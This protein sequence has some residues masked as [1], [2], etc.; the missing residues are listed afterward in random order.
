MDVFAWVPSYPVTDEHEPRLLTAVFGDGYDS[1]VGDGVNNDLATYPLS[2]NIRTL[3]EANAIV[4]FLK[5]HMGSP[6]LWTPP[7]GTQIQ[8]KCKQ[9]SRVLDEG[10]NYTVRATFKE[11]A[12]L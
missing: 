6:F 4:A 7:N 11:G 12:W 1:D 5:A 3:T 8:V 10:N 9:Y 2:F